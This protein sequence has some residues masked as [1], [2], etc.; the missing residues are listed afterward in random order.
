MN[1]KGLLIGA[2]AVAVSSVAAHAGW[3]YDN[4]NTTVYD[5]D[6]SFST[7]CA[8]DVG[9]GDEFAAQ[10]FTLSSTATI[11]EGA[12]S[13]LVFSGPT[14]SSVNYAIYA[15]V[16]GLPSGAALASGGLADDDVGR[17]KRVLIS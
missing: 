1:M 5:G 10:Q 17:P 6:C 4:L 15:A 13:D 11:N 8:A 14:A 7:T 2:A 3:V 9:R 12:F 16:G